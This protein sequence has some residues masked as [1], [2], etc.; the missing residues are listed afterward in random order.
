MFTAV[1]LSSPH[2]DQSGKCA[3]TTKLWM[4]HN[5]ACVIALVTVLSILPPY[6]TVTWLIFNFNC[7][8]PVCQLFYT[9]T[10]YLLGGVVANFSASTTIDWPVRKLRPIRVLLA[11]N[12]LSSD[13]TYL[14]VNTPV[15]YRS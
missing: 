5:P 6:Y 7:L 13:I 3:E 14:V 2:D 15:Y 11:I 10:N 1:L 12:L 8:S 9:G 4:Q